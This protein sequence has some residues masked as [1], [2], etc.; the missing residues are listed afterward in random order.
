MF[1]FRSVCTTMLFA[2]M[3][4]MLSIPAWAQ[5]LYTNG[6]VNGRVDALEISIDP[7]YSTYGSVA[8]SDSFTLSRTSTLFGAEFG[9]WELKGDSLESLDWAIGTSS[10]GDPF[11]QFTTLASGT[12]SGAGLTDKLLYVVN[13][14][15][16]YDIDSV[17]FGVGS[18]S[19]GPGTY[20]LTL[21][22][23][24][25]ANG[26]PVFWDENNGPSV[27]YIDVPFSEPP[28]EPAGQY[29]LHSYSSDCADFYGPFAGGTCS[30]AFQVYGVNGPSVPEPGTLTLLG[31][32]LLSLASLS[33]RRRV[34]SASSAAEQD[35]CGV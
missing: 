15:G 25:V 17:S 23:A 2:V 32:G 10:T 7:D 8:V 9:A 12:A 24:S 13:E 20:Y 34:R 16:G 3:L 1:L 31:I 30:E 19:L 5:T 21:S 29:N 35:A 27:G 6:P 26:D 28:G 18:L 11:T 22:G 33:F 14:Y 4:A